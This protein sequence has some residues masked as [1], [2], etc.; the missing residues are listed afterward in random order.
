MARWLEQVPTDF[1]DI[2][3]DV[4]EAITVQTYTET[5]NA[6]GESVRSWETY[7]D[8]TAVVQLHNGQERQQDE[9]LKGYDFYE[10]YLDHTALIDTDM[11]IKFGAKFL[12]IE[13]TYPLAGGLTVQQLVCTEYIGAST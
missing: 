7:L 8:T 6:D 2:N 5:I 9:Q 11:R 13:E 4:G 1:A 3:T 10:V 12:N